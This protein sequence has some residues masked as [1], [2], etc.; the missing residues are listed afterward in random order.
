MLLGWIIT[1]PVLSDDP[2]CPMK[3][4]VR[5]SLETGVDILSFS[6]PISR[7]DPL[8][9]REPIFGPPV[10]LYTR[11]VRNKLYT[12]RRLGRR[13]Y[14]DPRNT[15]ENS[16]IGYYPVIKTKSVKTDLDVFY[17]PTSSKNLGFAHV[18]ASS[19]LPSVT[20]HADLL[21]RNLGQQCFK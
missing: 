4:E 21:H 6:R 12:R 3:A 8:K 2:D 16:I 11:P 13:D 14:T 5:E 7:D 18:F 15:E 17:Q 1:L 10:Y 9:Y 19:V 20:F